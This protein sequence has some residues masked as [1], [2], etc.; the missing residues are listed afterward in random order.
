MVTRPKIARNLRPLGICSRLHVVEHIPSR[1]Q[2]DLTRVG[3]AAVRAFLG[4]LLIQS[5][6][7]DERRV[8]GHFAR[9]DGDAIIV[10]TLM[11]RNIP[12]ACSALV[13]AFR[14]HAENIAVGLRLDPPLDHGGIPVLDA[15]ADWLR[16]PQ[17]FVSWA[18]ALA[19]GP[20]IL[21][22]RHRVQVK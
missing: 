7:L 19:V 5:M 13:I 14:G 22:S 1:C 9:R 18:P 17:A 16:L 20:S 21:Y 12:S 4:D 2:L 3:G 15:H 11:A 6:F 10:R 8:W